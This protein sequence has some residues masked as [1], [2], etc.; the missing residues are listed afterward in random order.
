MRAGLA[1][2]GLILAGIFAAGPATAQ[3]I[4]YDLTTTS[5]MRINLPVSQA[6]TVVISSPVGKV[7]S[8]DPTIADAQP[9]TDRSVYLV[10]KTFGTTTVN[11]FSSE[12]APVGLLAVEV[13]ADTADMARSIKAAVPNS[14]VK[15]STVNG[16]VRLSGTVSDSES[17]QKV[18]D[19]VTQYGS[20]AIIN[21]MTLTGGQQVNLEV[22]ILEAQRDAGRK[23]GIS[24]EGSVG[25][26]GT[27]IGGGPENPS[28]GAGS[29][30]SFVTSVLSGV[31]GVSLTATINALE[32]KGLV[33][34]LAEP[35]LTTLSG[36][37]ASFLAGGQVPIRVADSNNNATLDY[38]DFGVRLEFTPV[39][40]S[41]GRI[42]IH[43]TPEVSGLAGTTGQNQDPIFNTRTLDA[44][45]ELRDGQSFSVAGLLQNDTSL[46]QNQLPWVGDVPVIGSLFKSSKYQKHETELVVIVT[47]RLV[48][49]SAPGQVAASPLDQTQPAND[50]EFFALGQMEVTSKMIKGF[51][52]GEGIAGP[53]GYII[54]LGS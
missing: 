25:G 23:L 32:T 37:K 20:P 16:R 50:V 10:G 22:R 30:S 2:L 11:L 18:L 13:G 14:S 24:W 19:V 35:N 51:Q 46:A 43:L 41:G 7:V 29:F 3:T 31:S 52:S 17:M 26:I 8:A 34:T 12:G 27:T 28:S 49:P 1:V 38:R 33:R 39:V 4:Q 47:P 9:I 36:V 45:V 21:T 15:V 53:Y 54:D 5:V 44:T 40:L 6:V 42:Q 48:Q